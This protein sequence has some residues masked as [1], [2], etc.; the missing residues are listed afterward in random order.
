M[1]TMGARGTLNYSAP[2]IVNIVQAK[3]RDKLNPE[4]C[5]MFSLGVVVIELI[6]TMTIE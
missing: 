3:T 5:D 1:V 6:F 4:K 2:E